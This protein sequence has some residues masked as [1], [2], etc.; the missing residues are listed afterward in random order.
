MRLNSK[1]SISLIIL[2]GFLSVGTSVRA[3]SIKSYI[4]QQIM[5]QLESKYPT[6][7]YRFAVDIK[8]L[9]Q[10]L[11][12][13]SR[14]EINKVAFQ[15]VGMPRDFAIYNVKYID[16]GEVRTAH[17]QAHIKVEEKL[18]VTLRRLLA[19]SVIKKSD[20][21]EHWVDITKENE[22][23]ISQPQK[24]SGLVVKH[25]INKGNPILWHELR[26]VP[27]INV[28][29]EVSLLYAQNGIRIILSCVARQPGAVG[30]KIRLFSQQT[31]KV[32]IG[33][34]ESSAK[35]IWE[36]TL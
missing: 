4:G 31:D 23:F 36:K 30:D 25:I 13:E 16:N 21:T 26:R 22:S 20:L 14:N 11:L 19:G 32:Y 8:W 6:D 10:N 24:L 33:K 34:V 29:D 15:G 5:N 28:G 3:Q 9:P 7:S 18:P 17:I 1:I 35:V 12:K 27:V 2:L